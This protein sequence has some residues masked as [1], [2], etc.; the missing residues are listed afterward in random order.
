[1][2]VPGGNDEWLQLADH[3]WID[4]GGPPDLRGGCSAVTRRDV[5]VAGMDDNQHDRAALDS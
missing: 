3:C 2:A 4:Q 5:P 1:M